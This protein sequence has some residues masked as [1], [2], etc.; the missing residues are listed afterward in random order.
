M[1]QIRGAVSRIVDANTFHVNVTWKDPQN[2]YAYGPTEII[3]ILLR[4]LARLVRLTS[5]TV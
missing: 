5:P 3:Q 2:R 1:D 4:N